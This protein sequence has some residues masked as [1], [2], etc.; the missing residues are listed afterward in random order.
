MTKVIN[1]SLNNYFY[2]LLIL[3]ITTLIACKPKND[4]SYINNDVSPKSVNT[5]HQIHIDKKI[6]VG[7]ERT[8]EYFEI[9]KNKKIALT[10][11]HTSF[12]GKHHL[13]DSLLSMGLDIQRIFAPEHG[14]RGEADA[15]A[16]VAHGKDEKTGIPIISLYGKRKKPLPED[17]KNID[18]VV[19][20]IQDVGAR[21]Y[22]YISTMHYIMEAC[23]EHNIPVLIL[24]RPNPNGHYVDGFILETSFS[25]F[26]GMHPIPVVHG[27][28]V[29][30]LAQMINGERWL[31]NKLKCDLKIIPCKN[32][33]HNSLYQLPIKPSPNLPNM[34]SI[35]LY[36][37][38]CF[39]EGTVVNIGRGTQQQFQVIG[40][41]NYPDT[42]FSYTPISRAGA[43]YPKHENKLCY[44]KNLTSLSL[45]DLQK[46]KRLNLN[47]IIDFYNNYPKK[48]T[49][50]LKNNFI[51][52][53]AG[54]DLLKKY[55][56]EGKTEKEIRTAWK[57]ELGEYLLM[58]K[59]YLLYNDF[60]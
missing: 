13:V 6:E 50:F 2:I 46:E 5:S 34:R 30:E 14:F 38:L 49:F 42:N 60:N 19:F 47:Y 1:M 44:G 27:L 52:K 15:G 48:E 31:K 51:H 41:P 12:I 28:T 36:P 7:A 21:F 25:S 29:G 43:K 32:Y 57:K 45:E 53:L 26:V 35:Y 11:N 54:T 20:D 10:V 55:I 22:T 23:A 4:S 37:S 39:F 8:E 3:L 33:D 9:L 56:I 18:I 58:R 40:D 17:L 59:K 16:T 24:D